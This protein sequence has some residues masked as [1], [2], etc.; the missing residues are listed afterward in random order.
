MVCN[1]SPYS[2]LIDGDFMKLGLCLRTFVLVATVSVM[3]CNSNDPSSSSANSK[4]DDLSLNTIGSTTS[5]SSTPESENLIANSQ[6]QVVSGL[7][8]QPKMNEE[9]TGTIGVLQVNSITPYAA[10]SSVVNINITPLPAS[11]PN[12][13]FPNELFYLDPGCDPQLLPQRGTALRIITVTGNPVTS[14]TALAPK[15]ATQFQKT[16]S[17]YLHMVASADYTGTTGN[18]ADYWTKYPTQA[19]TWLEDSPPNSL[20]GATREIAVQMVSSA[21]HEMCQYLP[22]GIVTELQG[23]VLSFGSM[24]KEQ[25]S[26]SGSGS[27][28]VM[29]DVDGQLSYSP[30]TPATSGYTFISESVRV[31]NT[32]KSIMV[33]GVFNDTSGSVFYFAKPIAVIGSLPSE[34]YSQPVGEKLIPLVVD[35]TQDIYGSNPGFNMPSTLYDDPFFVSSESG[36]YGFMVDFY[37]ETA[38]AVHWSTTELNGDFEM[39]TPTA[40][41]GGFAFMDVPNAYWIPGSAW[42]N[43]QVANQVY[44]QTQDLTLNNG[45]A[46]FAGA[47][48]VQINQ[49]NVDI[50]GFTLNAD[51]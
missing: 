47:K 15:G 30:Q 4:P 6:F 2:K 50:F 24:I 7:D 40:A 32:A 19:I 42:L 14:I 41:A 1:Q 23:Q 3:G 5:S 21:A 29:I 33:C 45:F 49:A 16:N 28:Q 44:T 37:G 34:Y 17:C 31:S 8:L 25:I 48:G 20:P 27:A 13:P 11:N 18:S 12:Q 35:N 46:F 51:H 38:G 36:Y 43:V 22:A 10:G 9:A 39:S 26:K